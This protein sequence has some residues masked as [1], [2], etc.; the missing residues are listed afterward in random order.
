MKIFTLTRQDVKKQEITSYF[1]FNLN[2]LIDYIKDD[3]LIDFYY[4]ADATSYIINLKRINDFILSNTNFVLFINSLYENSNLILITFF[5]KLDPKN[6]Y[7]FIMHSKNIVY[8][9]KDLMQKIQNSMIL[10]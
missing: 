8:F 4:P 5:D 7:I 1:S 2:F 9:D 10:R 3:N 6:V